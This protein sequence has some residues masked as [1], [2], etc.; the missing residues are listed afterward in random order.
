MITYLTKDLATVTSGII[1]HGCNAQGAMGSGVAGALRRMWPEIYG[2]YSKM[3]D[4]RKNKCLGM[5]DV[6]WIAGLP[7]LVVMN[8]ITQEF[9]GSDGKKY[10]NLDAIHKTLSFAC[11][12]SG[13]NVPVYAPKIGCGLGG[14]DWE[15]EVRPYYERVTNEYPEIDLNVCDI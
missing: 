15:T 9:Y 7:Q 1:I 6:V 12:F 8:A 5:V 2:A 4:M 13:G 14:F 10:A 11:A 3:C